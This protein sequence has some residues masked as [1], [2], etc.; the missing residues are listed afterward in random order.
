MTLMVLMTM[1]VEP[2]RWTRML[3][4]RRFVQLRRGALAAVKAGSARWL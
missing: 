2:G 1:Y 4:V 3:N